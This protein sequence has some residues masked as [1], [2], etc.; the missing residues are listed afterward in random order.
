VT[1]APGN[2]VR[3]KRGKIVTHYNGTPPRELALVGTKAASSGVVIS[4]YRPSGPLRTGSF[5]DGAA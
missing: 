1:N 2:I 5:D 3:M 4:T